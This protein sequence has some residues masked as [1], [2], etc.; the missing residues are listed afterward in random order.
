[1]AMAMA[2]G[3]ADTPMDMGTEACIKGHTHTNDIIFTIEYDII[4]YYYCVYNGLTKIEG[5]P[6]PLQFL[7]LK[8]PAHPEFLE[9]NPPAHPEFLEPNPP[10]HPEFLEQTPRHIP[11]S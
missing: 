4:S 3:M 1:M 2:M 6:F 7:E 8:P 5:R 9:L 10:A 11:D